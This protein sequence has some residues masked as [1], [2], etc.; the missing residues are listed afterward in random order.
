MRKKNTVFR[1]PQMTVLG[2]SARKNLKRRRFR[3]GAGAA[4]WFPLTLLLVLTSCHIHRPQTLNPPV[5]TGN[6]EIR[7]ALQIV[8]E[9]YLFPDRIE[10][11]A[12]F[13]GAVKRV[14]TVVPDL[15]LEESAGRFFL[16]VG[17]AGAEGR[18]ER[19]RVTD[20]ESL[21]DL[22]EA[23]V[24]FVHTHARDAPDP[25]KLR[26]AALAGA[27]ATLDCHSRAFSAAASA[28]GEHQLSGRYVGIG[29]RVAKRDGKVVFLDLFEGGTAM[30]RGIS[31]GDELVAINGEAVGVLS[32]AEVIERL[33]GETGSIVTVRVARHNGGA[34]YDVALLRKSVTVRTTELEVDPSGV[35]I[36]RIRSITRATADE[37]RK[38]LIEADQSGRLPPAM[39]L[40]LRG[41]SGGSLR[42]AAYLADL[43]LGDGLMVEVQGRD[44]GPVRGLVSSLRGSHAA[45]DFD[46]P[47]GVLVDQ[48]TAS[49]AELLTLILQRLGRAVVIGQT[50]YGKGVVQKL[51]AVSENIALNLTV[52]R[53]IVG[54][55]PLPPGGIVPDVPLVESAAAS[56][57][58][59][60]A[61][62][63]D[64]GTR[65]AVAVLLRG[66]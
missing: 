60:S 13:A 16:A 38:N 11:G 41:N 36:V 14:A 31:P 29:A 4:A 17:T 27:L 44:G 57:E 66:A 55:S 35:L 8:W 10:P 49:S 24:A 19:D 18:I 50:T 47:V 53:Y 46:G 33:R 65:A 43:F 28:E 25:A 52:A 9:R 58:Q 56:G 1:V 51:Y 6:A 23:V 30:E 39:L 48:K 64:S 5:G 62:R 22:L 63:T 2:A 59:K 32:V 45:C 3:F 20:M 42:G 54:G 61:E 15:T 21:A 12:M 26:L 7:A 37:I 40:D 34:D